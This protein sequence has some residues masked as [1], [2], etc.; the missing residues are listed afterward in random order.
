[1]NKYQIIYKHKLDN[2]ER[3]FLTGK[4]I[5]K[6]Y[7]ADTYHI[8][9]RQAREYISTLAKKLP[10]IS[11]SSQKGYKM[12]EMKKEDY[13]SAVHALR[14]MQKRRKEIELREKP[15][16]EHVEELRCKYGFIECEVE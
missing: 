6:Q 9:E 12:A 4:R 2:I 10:I 3:E 14:E 5:T 13:S 1:M 11:V 16:L 7:I 8:S 15:L